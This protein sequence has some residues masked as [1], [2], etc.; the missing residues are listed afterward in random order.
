VVEAVGPEGAELAAVRRAGGHVPAPTACDEPE[1]LDL[2]RAPRAVGAR[3][4]DPERAPP[5]H[6][7][8][9]EEQRLA[10]GRRRL[11]L[12]HQPQLVAQALDSAGKALREHAGDLRRGSLGAAEPAALRHHEAEDDRGGLLVREHQRRQ[13]RARP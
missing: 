7:L 8:G 5:P 6:R 11:G 1:R 9:D 3:V 4:A 13:P 10:G 12:A 2:A